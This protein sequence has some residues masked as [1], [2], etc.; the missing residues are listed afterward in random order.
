MEADE[1]KRGV[2]LSGNKRKDSD[3]SSRG[4]MGSPRGKSHDSSDSEH[5]WGRG[6]DEHQ[7]SP[8]SSRRRTSGETRLDRLVRRPSG[9]D[10]RA[11]ALPKPRRTQKLDEEPLYDKVAADEEQEDEYDNHLLYGQ[12]ATTSPLVF[13]SSTENDTGSPSPARRAVRGEEEEGNYVNIQYFLHQ[14]QGNDASRSLQRLVSDGDEGCDSEEE[15]THELGSTG[16]GSSREQ[17]GSEAERVVMYRHI[18]N[19]IVE[20]EAIYLECLSV[21]LQ[22][23]KAMK[24]KQFPKMGTRE[25][26]PTQLEGNQKK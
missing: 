21:S 13:S 8:S 22:Y 7:N 26:L 12:A 10:S 11:P 25:R 2:S 1:R 14:N 9:G 6:R 15:D 16:S 18:L 24:P 5:S 4:R 23:M 19:S 3:S 17:T 20:S